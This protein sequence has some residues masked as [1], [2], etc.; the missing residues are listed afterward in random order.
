MRDQKALLI[1]VLA[2]AVST[3]ALAQAQG[4]AG[5]DWPHWRGP[6]RTG[7]TPETSGWDQGAWPPLVLW[8]RQVGAGATSPIMADG[9]VY[10]MGWADDAD[11]IYCIDLA[12]GQDVWTRSY[13]CPSYG[14]YHQ[15]D[16][17]HYLG[18]SSTPEYDAE[19][20]YLYTV[21]LD[22]D[23]NCWDARDGGAHV[24]GVNLY[25]A[26][27]VP[28]RPAVAGV[29]RDYGYTS[30][31][32]VHGDWVIAEVGSP[33]GTLMAFDRRSG[34]LKWVSECTSPAGHTGGLVPITVQGVSCVAVLTAEGLLVARADPGHEGQTAAMYDWQ[35]QGA[36]NIPTP[37]ALDDCII[38]STSYNVHKTARLKVSLEGATPVWESQYFTRVA[39]PVIHQ[40]RVYLASQRLRCLDYETGALV[41]E[42]D[43]VRDDASCIVSGDGRLIVFTSGN[44]HLVESAERSSGEYRHLATANGP[45]RGASWPHV[46]AGGGRLLAKDVAGNLSCLHLTGETGVAAEVRPAGPV[47]VTTFASDGAKPDWG[48]NWGV[49]PQVEGCQGEATWVAEDAEGGAGGSM[50]VTYDIGAEPRSFSM[51][52][53]PGR[54]VN[55]SAY[56]RFVIWAKGDVPS[57]TLVVKDRSADPDGKTDAGIADLLVTGVTGQW[58]RF[59]LPFADLVPRVVGAAIDWHAI[60]HVG[61][62]MVADRNAPSGTLQV[63][64]LRALPLD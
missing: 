60:N 47:A 23:L 51:W 12:S 14:R 16:E 62:A 26:Y 22:G 6:D 15:G 34:A 43:S 32:L 39:S 46:A 37:A 48:G 57:F 58:Q 17:G 63:D 56:D 9:L 30:S 64:D 5:A 27:H 3:A 24:W 52:L 29:L 31:P 45:D 21:G 55:L 4:R 2:V 28:Q 20:G 18:P 19:T 41:W 42:G 1:V 54:D 36:A 10:V 44:L 7:V 13:R 25:D 53:A 50:R 8:T 35:T 11:T 49:W 38:I 33:E 61:V 40:G 59:E